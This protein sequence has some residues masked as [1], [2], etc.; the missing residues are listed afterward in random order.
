[1]GLWNDYLFICIKLYNLKGSKKYDRFLSLILILRPFTEMG[2][3]SIFKRPKIGQ[4]NS[5]FDMAYLFGL[6]E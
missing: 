4:K 1:V 6:V 2:V 3:L 5:D